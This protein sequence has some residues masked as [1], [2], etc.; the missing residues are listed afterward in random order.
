MTSAFSSNDSECITRDVEAS[1]SE[2]LLDEIWNETRLSECTEWINKHDFKKV[3]E[4][5]HNRRANKF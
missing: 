5:K 1:N 4:A 3:N 2:S